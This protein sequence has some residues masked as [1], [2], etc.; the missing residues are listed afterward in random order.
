MMGSQGEVAVGEGVM[1]LQMVSS[2]CC[3]GRVRGDA[4]CHGH[5]SRVDTDL[6][7]EG[8]EV[9]STCTTC[10]ATVSASCGRL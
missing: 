1:E 10:S 8:G 7:V 2:L 9:T 6:V 4:E 3:C 5:V